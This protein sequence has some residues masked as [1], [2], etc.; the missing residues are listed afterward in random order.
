MLAPTTHETETF[1]NL[2]TILL[3]FLSKCF[4][5]QH[6]RLVPYGSVV[7]GLA[8][9]G[10]RCSALS[11]SPL[12]TCS[13]IAPSDADYTVIFEEDIGCLTRSQ[14]ETRFAM[15]VP[16]L[17]QVADPGSFCYIRTA[18]VP[19]VKFALAQV[20][21]DFT[22]NCVEAEEASDFIKETIN[23]SPAYKEAVLL[24]KHYLTPKGLMASNKGGMSSFVL[25]LVVRF[26]FKVN[27][28][29]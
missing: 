7:T 10:T 28:L 3:E 9:P 25:S 17:R 15:L 13:T 29:I 14:C 2:T 18:K 12:C 24:L 27:M 11:S 16:T 4:P 20:E 8:I 21:I 5:N 22:A 19:V 6:F 1:S 23:E 26:C